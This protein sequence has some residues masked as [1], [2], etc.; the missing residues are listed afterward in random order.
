[1]MRVD[2]PQTLKFRPEGEGLSTNP[3]NSI[4]EE[5]AK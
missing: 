5:G 1:M 2:F 3:K 4:F